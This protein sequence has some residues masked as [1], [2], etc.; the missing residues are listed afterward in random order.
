[1]GAVFDPQP[2]QFGEK[3]ENIVKKVK[4]MCPL[5][6]LNPRPSDYKSC[7]FNRTS[8]RL[9]MQVFQTGVSVPVVKKGNRHAVI[10]SR[11][12][13]QSKLASIRHDSFTTSKV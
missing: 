3:E 2:S 8:S 10:S 12:Y 9:A 1:M 13:L 11:M 4:K 5:P 7:S 6:D